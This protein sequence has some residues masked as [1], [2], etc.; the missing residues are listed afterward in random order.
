VSS[1]LRIARFAHF[2]HLTWRQSSACTVVRTARP[3][4][5]A[6]GANAEG[7]SRGSGRMSNLPPERGLR[8]A[9]K[10]VRRRVEVFVWMLG[11]YAKPHVPVRDALG[12]AR[13]TARSGELLGRWPET[14]SGSTHRRC[15]PRGKPR[16]SCSTWVSIPRS[17]RGC[18]SVRSIAMRSFFR[19]GIGRAR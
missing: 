10:R 13:K 9:Q 1:P 2:P 12:S 18:S 3:P 11:R 17:G 16:R 14:G 7:R 6:K 19:H 15:V 4:N 8:R 5:R